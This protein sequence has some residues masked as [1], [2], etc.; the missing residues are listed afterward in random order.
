[1][2]KYRFKAENKM[3]GHTTLKELKKYCSSSDGLDIVT[4]E[5]GLMG[6]IVRLSE[7]ERKKAISEIESLSLDQ[8]RFLSLIVGSICYDRYSFK[9]FEEFG[10]DYN[11]ITAKDENNILI[12]EYLTKII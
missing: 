7:E 5:K 9:R 10:L 2:L 3:A 4:K 8:K 1:M 12:M 6:L 11:N